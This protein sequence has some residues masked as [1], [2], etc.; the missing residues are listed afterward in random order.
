METVDDLIDLIP[1]STPTPTA[2]PT[3]TPK[4]LFN[5]PV[6][7]HLQKRSPLK[8]GVVVSS[9]Y[10]SQPQESRSISVGWI[11]IE[12]HDTGH[13][14]FTCVEQ[15]SLEG[16]DGT[17]SWHHK[18]PCNHFYTTAHPENSPGADGNRRGRSV[19][20]YNEKGKCDVRI[21]YRATTN[22]GVGW[23]GLT[24][25]TGK[26]RYRT[27]WYSWDQRGGGVGSETYV[28]VTVAEGVRFVR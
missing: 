28:T 12:N 17:Y 2:T 24:T 6:K 9:L 4:P 27:Q 15:T 25:K 18:E 7:T 26:K 5:L 1:T 3:P 16:P 21:H 8:P 23:L 14:M 13:T 11:E 10:W 19:L 20:V 22:R